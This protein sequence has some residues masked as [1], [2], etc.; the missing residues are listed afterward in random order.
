MIDDH[1]S[2]QVNASQAKKSQSLAVSTPENKGKKKKT[3]APLAGQTSLDFFI[4]RG[5]QK[6]T[7]T[8][9]SPEKAK[10]V[11]TMP[12]PRLTASAKKRAKEIKCSPEEIE[13]EIVLPKKR[14]RPPKDAKEA[15]IVNKAHKPTKRT[16]PEPSRT[17][18]PSKPTSKKNSQTPKTSQVESIENSSQQVSQG[19]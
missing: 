12:S 5:Q 14:G 2:S 6:K 11:N 10:N 3:I 4:K 8:P 19:Q 7:V 9:S 16:A 1:K 17:T 13:D 18:Q 15:N